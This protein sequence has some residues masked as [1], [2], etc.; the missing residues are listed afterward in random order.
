MLVV[1]MVWVS[2]LRMRSHVL[3]QCYAMAAESPKVPIEI[4]FNP[5]ILSDNTGFSDFFAPSL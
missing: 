3:K 4:F 1:M 2:F 5:T